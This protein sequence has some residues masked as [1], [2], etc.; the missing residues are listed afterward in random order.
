MSTPQLE[1]LEYATLG[2]LPGPIRTTCVEGAAHRWRS[3]SVLQA[4]PSTPRGPPTP[5]GGGSGGP[6]EWAPGNRAF[7][8]PVPPASAPSSESSPP[9]VRKNS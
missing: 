5:S 1:E 4:Q 7:D 8:L 6:T 9:G 2:L 3:G